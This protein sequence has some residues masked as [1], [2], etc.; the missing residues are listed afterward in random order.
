MAKGKDAQ[1]HIGIFGRRNKGKS[2]LINHIS[3]QD[4]SIV[5]EI[6]GT[7]TDP[8]KKSIEIPKIGAAILID[9]AGIDDVGDLGQQR[10]KRTEQVI[11]IID[12]AII[13][14]SNNELSRF[15]KSLVYLLEERSVPYFFVHN[16]SDIQKA[17]LAFRQRI[18]NDFNTDVID[19]SA[20]QSTPNLELV[21]AIQKYLPDSAYIKQSMLGGIIRKDD[22]VLLVTPIDTEA[23]EGRLILPQVQ[24][25]RDIL[26]NDAVAIVLKE[27]EI[28][29]F[30]KKTAIKPALVITDSQMFKKVAAIVPKDI[31]LTGF[32]VLLARFKGDFEAYLKG[33]P[34]IAD[35]K[36]GDKVLILESCTHHVTCDDIG[37]VKIPDWMS[38]FTGKK[39]TFVTVAGLNSVPGEISDYSLIIQCGGCVITRKQILGRLKPAKDADISLSNYGMAIAYLHGVYDRAIAPFIMPEK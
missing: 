12:L 23:P 13:V 15:E 20:L 24:A 39:L 6:P 26:D 21:A 33:T 28:D 18:L 2:S 31:P 22:I 10:I 19:L 34:K 30:L 36:D 32:S 29:T 14:L 4:I 16:K 38:K 37:R 7:T 17:E 11:N 35:L 5:S 27:N 8:V 25:I 3:G 1:A 9:T